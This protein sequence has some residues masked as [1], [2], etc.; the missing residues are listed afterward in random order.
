[1][2]EQT[3][4]CL[5][6]LALCA[7]RT[8][9]SLSSLSVAQTLCST[10]TSTVLWTACSCGYQ[11]LS[12]AHRAAIPGSRLCAQRPAQLASRRPC[13]ARAIERARRVY[14]SSIRRLR[15]SF[16]LRSRVSPSFALAS[17]PV[18]GPTALPSSNRNPLTTRANRVRTPPRQLSRPS[19][20]SLSLCDISRSP[21]PLVH[22]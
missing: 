7:M 18:L 1:M 15:P 14:N 19:P 17:P 22:N 13:P 4:V 6:R 21:S 8:W 9:T 11:S 16:P 12:P 3:P 2:R 5:S 20:C 10:A